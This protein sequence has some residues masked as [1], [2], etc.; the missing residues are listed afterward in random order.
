M[1]SAYFHLKKQFQALFFFFLIFSSGFAVKSFAQL[2]I[3][4]CS[5]TLQMTNV[6]PNGIICPEDNPCTWSWSGAGLTFSCST[7]Q[8][9]NITAPGPGTYSA[10]IYFSGASNGSLTYSLTFGADDGDMDG[11]NDCDDCDDNNP[12]I[13]PNTVW[14]LDADNDGYYTGTGITQCASPGTFYRYAGLIGG[15]DCNDSNPAVN[16]GAAEICDNL[17]NNCNNQVNEGLNLTYY[18]D[19]DNDGFGNPGNTLLACSLPVGYVT[20]NSD[21]DD[22]NG[23]INPNTVWYLD[24]DNDNYYT[25]SP[26][27]QCTSPG[28]GY[29]YT[30]L[31][32]GGDCNDG[33]SGINPGATEI[34]DNLD[35]NCNNQTDEGVLNTFYRDMDGDSYGDPNISQQACSAPAGFVANN[36]DCD[37]NNPNVNPGTAEI[38][39]N[40]DNNCNNQVDDG[41]N[42]CPATNIIYVNDDASGNNDGTSWT[43]AFN[44]LQ[45][46]LALAGNCPNVTEIW[47]AAGTY[48]PTSGTDRSISFSMVTG[49]AIY[50][51][52]NGMETQLSERNWVSNL[53]MLSGDIGIQGNNSDNS[54]NVIKNE[55]NGLNNSAILDGFTVTAGNANQDY[56]NNNAGGGL[57][58]SWVS[59]KIMNCTFKENSALDGGG[60]YNSNATPAIINCRFYNNVATNSFGAGIYTIGGSPEIINCEFTG[61]SAAVYGGALFNNHCSSPIVNCIFKG[62]SAVAGAAIASYINSHEQITNCTFT[63]NSASQSGGG[64]MSFS[65][66]NNVTVSNC[67]F[68]ENTKGG[69]S[70]VPGADIENGQ[71]TP[72][73]T[74]SGTLLQLQQTS[75]GANLNF[76]SGNIFGSDPLFIEN[77]NP[78]APD[79]LLS[80]N[81]R[82]SPCSPAIDAGNNNPFP[83]GITTDLDGNPR[84]YDNGIVD[85]GAYEYQDI[86]IDPVNDIPPLTTQNGLSFDGTDDY[87]E[88]FDNCGDNTFFPGG[89]AITVAYWF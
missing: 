38:C 75:Y 76:G 20:N 62:N 83:A 73:V 48:K 54:F 15:G 4:L 59:P 14:Y 11:F 16:P 8:L 12:G 55:N 68:W 85:M 3:P 60:I 19:A 47:V 45:D 26:M 87:V 67:I 35:N 46:A 32:G 80:G 2:S 86:T 9:T 52:F 50:G 77:F 65:F 41:I 23:A 72:Y 57:F 37:D 22:N 81:L 13:N 39:D 17:D 21:C 43:D 40:L 61:N 89:D 24:A 79:P 71:N 63:A 30:G 1:F 42:C 6:G 18:R 27:V 78:S 64:L 66:T 56:L 5:T 84:F 70:Q 58:N 31:V 10:T 69:S 51:G 29:R 44:D 49:V 53:T 36:T 25:G 88:V 33:H 74:I 82:L 7:C 28:T 34:C